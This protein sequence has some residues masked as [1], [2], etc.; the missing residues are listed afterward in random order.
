VQNPVL[1]GALLSAAG[2]P[3]GCAA[4][5]S[6]LCHT[7]PEPEVQVRCLTDYNTALGLHDDTGA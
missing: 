5:A 3:S 1:A 4:N 6:G 7:P 2:S